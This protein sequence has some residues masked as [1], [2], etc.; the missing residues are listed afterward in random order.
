MTCTNGKWLEKR[1][2]AKSRS[3]LRAHPELYTHQTKTLYQENILPLT[4]SHNADTTVA[5][6]VSQAFIL[7]ACGEESLQNLTPWFNHTS[8]TQVFGTC[9]NQE[10][11]KVKPLPLPKMR[12]NDLG[13]VLV[14]LH[15]AGRETDGCTVLD[16]RIHW[17]KRR[18]LYQSDSSES[19]HFVLC[20]TTLS[21]FFT[22]I[23][24]VGVTTS[25]LLYGS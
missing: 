3:L 16:T 13:L 14:D 12:E 5:L 2:Q 20:T 8:L 10:R 18:F 19:E 6:F 4:T 7:A 23:S 11:T 25:H 22:S 1:T 17:K 15:T 9:M 24:P 21:P